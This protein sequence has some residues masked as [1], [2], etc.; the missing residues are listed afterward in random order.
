M[1][2]YSVWS[3]SA[4]KAV[5]TF[6]KKTAKPR[7]STKATTTAKAKKILCVAN[8]RESHNTCRER[9]VKVS[10]S[11]F[12][13][14]TFWVSSCWSFTA[15]SIVTIRTLHCDGIVASTIWS[16]RY[17]D[18]SPIC[19]CFRWATLFFFCFLFDIET[20]TVQ[21]YDDL[22]ILTF[23]L[24]SFSPNNVSMHTRKKQQQHT[25]RKCSSRIFTTYKVACDRWTM[26][27]CIRSV[28]VI[29]W[30]YE[31][32]LCVLRHI[33]LETKKILIDMYVLSSSTCSPMDVRYSTKVICS[34]SSIATKSNSSNQE[35]R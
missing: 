8:G 13:A 25:C 9:R 5:R 12:W 28:Q 21:S 4:A 32:R 10:I 1:E 35:L 20:T 17:F 18:S 24:V 2:S 26:M 34:R 29:R 6:S 19:V 11:L 22:E 15:I 14:I 23:S 31:R 16:V 3:V 7:C 30:A 33:D 27:S